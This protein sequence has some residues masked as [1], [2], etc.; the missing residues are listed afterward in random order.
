MNNISRKIINILEVMKLA[1]HVDDFAPETD[2][3]QLENGTLKLDGSFI[4]A[5]RTLY[6]ADHTSSRSMAFFSGLTS[7]RGGSGFGQPP[8]FSFDNKETVNNLE[9]PED[10]VENAEMA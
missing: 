8:P 10:N 1:A 9:H 5:S 4:G 2:R 3:I 6:G 7:L